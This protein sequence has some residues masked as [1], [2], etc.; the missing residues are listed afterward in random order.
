MAALGLTIPGS[1]GAPPL[2]FTVLGQS[3]NN[4]TTAFS[5]D[6]ATAASANNLKFFN[7]ADSTTSG[8]GTV[9]LNELIQP[10]EANL[11]TGYTL[12]TGGEY[13]FI[14][15]TTF[16]TVTGSTTG[17]DT[18]VATGLTTYDAVGDG[19]EVNFLYGD[20]VYN[21]GTSTN[22]T[23]TGGAGFDTINTGTGS[24]LVFGGYGRDVINLQDTTGNADLAYLGD[25]NN[26]V[27]ADGVN[28]LVVT[29]VSGQT[30]N[31]ATSTTAG[32][33]N[34]LTVDIESKTQ[35][36]YF[37]GNDLVNAGSA[38][39][40]VYD[41]IGGNTIY[42]G[43]GSLN[44][45]GGVRPGLIV[46]DTVV[47]G[48]GGGNIYAAADNNFNISSGTDTTGGNT[49]NVIA[50]SGNE[51]LNGG[52]AG[53]N[54]VFYGSQDTTG[55]ANDTMIGGSGSNI[56][57][58]GTGNEEIDAGAGSNL[59]YLEGVANSHVTVFDFAASN[60]LVG[61]GSAISGNESSILADAT[62]GTVAGAGGATVDTVTLSLGNNSTVTFVGI[63]SLNGKIV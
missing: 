44:V 61:F 32:T 3:L 57:I 12:G 59:L 42:G 10:N 48:S 36:P 16:T 13:S 58:T 30:I 20:N 22:D 43:S 7:L 5:N 33:H 45:V 29:G 39:L 62:T 14:D 11:K 40:L 50:G 27:N 34:T 28:D 63:D 8:S 56:F 37:G 38:N 51:T 2:V 21:G 9:V 25:G 26:F 4:M 17:G 54:L 18:V 1:N 19:N 35:N 6:L 15:T 49:I 47:A 24:N 31:G 52:S 60:D 41:T 55:S 23:I 53:G 46:A